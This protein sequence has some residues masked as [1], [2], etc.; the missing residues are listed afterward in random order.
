VA[1]E[2]LTLP[3]LSAYDPPEAGEGSIDPVGVAAIS[4]RLADR[5]VP[6]LRARM[7]RV[8]FVTAMAV[9]AS[10]CDALAGEVAGDGVSTPSICFE[11][12]V[13]EA[14]ARRLP[15]GEMPPNVPGSLKARSVIARN[16]RLSHS[17]YLKGPTVF[18]F[19]GVYKPFAVDAGVVGTEL[20]PGVRCAEL[21]HAWEAEQ[22]FAGF[23]DALPN[24]EGG[25]FRKQVQREVRG[26]LLA[27]H[28]TTREKSWL[29][30]YLANALHPDGAR[31]VERKVLRS[32][33]TT[34]EH[35]TRT[36]LARLLVSVRGD[37]TEAEILEAV[38]PKATLHLG[39]VIDAV[40]AYERFAALIDASFRML[41]FA[42]R[43]R[44]TQ[45]LTS[46]DV[47][48]NDIIVTAAR[49]L[50]D[51]YRRA[52]DAMA[53]I[54]AADGLEEQLGDFA[55]PRAP[56]DLVALLFDHH[57]SVQGRKPPNGKRPWFEPLRDGHVVRANYGAEHPELGTS[58]VHPIRVAALRE[59]VE[60]SASP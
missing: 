7:R 27:G 24:T 53:T 49:E 23:T 50:P 31:H 14:F 19:N 51:R 30:G 39:Q 47:E 59:F 43:S 4:D 40:T 41:C 20:E 48:T 33:V 46:A 22:G 25:R 15:A 34:G 18:G 9:G 11:W 56:R 28:C 32:L 37:C 42:S 54:G 12:L 57:K 55:I 13:I 45:P 16:A 2:A 60:E 1:F 21:T 10:V 3:Q 58:F 26:A 6:G 5:L 8:R 17:T 29:F 36:E 38:R 44:G 35:T 52:Q